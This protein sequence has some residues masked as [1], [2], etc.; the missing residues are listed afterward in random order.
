MIS[1][2]TEHALAEA[3]QIQLVLAGN[4]QMFCELVKPHQRSLYHKALSIIGNEA[5]A[6]EAVQN[7]VFKA[8]N[9]LHQ[10]RHESQFRSWLMSITINEA[11]MWLRRNRNLRLESLDVENGNGERVPLELAD[12]RESPFQSM[13]RRQ[14]RAAILK[15][16]TRLPFGYSQV[17]ILR[18]LR[19][20]SISETAK[21]L[22]ISE[23]CVKTRLRRGRGLMRRALAQTGAGRQRRNSVSSP[24]Q[25]STGSVT[26]SIQ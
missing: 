14:V 22:G 23:T 10:F 8:F 13:E 3:A 7:A 11:R 9:K 1:S 19:M 2:E 17:F 18:D 26:G 25:P 4:G 16:M 6:E 5:D 20:L 12:P 21:T 15:A 24:G